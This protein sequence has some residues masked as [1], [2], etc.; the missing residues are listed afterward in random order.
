MDFNMSLSAEYTTKLNGL[1]QPG[2][3]CYDFAGKV[4]I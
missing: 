2:I 1:W 4:H 3:N